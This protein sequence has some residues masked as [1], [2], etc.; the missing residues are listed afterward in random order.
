MHVPSTQCIALVLRR[1][2]I[3]CKSVALHLSDN[4]VILGEMLGKTMSGLRACV[5][6]CVCVYHHSGR[7]VLIWRKV[8]IIRS[9]LMVILI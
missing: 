8:L 7:I 1:I 6:V 2:I 5:C 9:N 3:H 4:L